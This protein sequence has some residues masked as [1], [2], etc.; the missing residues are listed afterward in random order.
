MTFDEW[1]EI[2]D[3]GHS[4][5]VK[6]DMRAAW[7]ASSDSQRWKWPKMDSRPGEQTT[8]MTLPWSQWDGYA[9][10]CIKNRE[11]Q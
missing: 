3:K 11:A 7:K 1:Y 6:A 4:D 2:Q 9:D 5:E 8:I 10:Q